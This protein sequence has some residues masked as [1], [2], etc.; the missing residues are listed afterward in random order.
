MAILEEQFT[1]GYLRFNDDTAASL[2]PFLTTEPEGSEF[3]KSWDQT[4]RSL[5]EF[6]SLR[7]L[8]DFSHFLPSSD[9]GI[10][11]NKFPPLFHAHLHGR[12]LGA[13]EIFWDGE[14]SEPL[15][16]GQSEV[17]EGTFFFDIWTSFS[18]PVPD[19]GA[20]ASPA[21]ASPASASPA[22]E[23]SIS[24]FQ[25][26]AS[27]QPPTMLR[28]TTDLKLR[29]RDGG[30][31]TLLF[32]LSRYLKL[33]AV[34]AAGHPIDFIQNPAM[35][36]TALQ[37]KGNDLV[38]VVFPSPLKTGQELK[39]RFH[40]A[41]EVLSDAGNGLL[42]VGGR[43]TWYPNF[44]FAPAQFEMEFHYPANWTLVATGKQ[45]QHTGGEEAETDEH[46]EPGRASGTVSERVPE[47]VSRWVSERPIPVAGFNLGKYVRAEAKAGDVLVEAYGTR[48]VEKTFPKARPEVIPRFPS[49]PPRQGSPREGMQQLAVP[50]PPPSPARDAQAVADRAARAITSF[51]RWF[52]PYPLFLTGT[53]PDARKNPVRDG[54]AWFFLSSF[55]FP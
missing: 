36:G 47:K 43:G 21:N 22:N 10:S 13:F 33:D 4:S 39:M 28:A 26:Q 31:R 3:I 32:E 46:A 41:G 29:I 24:S 9:P 15:W 1:S 27:V 12:K 54:Q 35:E 14:N 11:E 17:K 25:I 6:D 40:Y 18:P 16:A 50:P 45:V 37:R 20:S 19:R 48:G 44:G 42:Y 8:L 51:S 30:E 2:H 5:A 38:A 49:T 52:G 34:E 23:A 53:D 7:L 55:R